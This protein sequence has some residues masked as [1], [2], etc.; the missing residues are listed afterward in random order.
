MDFRQ[1]IQRFKMDLLVKMPFYGVLFSKLNIRESDRDGVAWT[2]GREI[3]YN[4]KE[5]SQFTLDEFHYVL[6]HELLHIILLHPFRCE[7]RNPLLWNVAC[8]LSVNQLLDE[9]IAPAMKRENIPFS[10]PSGV[11]SMRYYTKVSTETIYEVLKQ[12]KK[13]H[14]LLGGSVYV[15]NCYGLST[16]GVGKTLSGKD[17]PND[18]TDAIKRMG[19]S[20]DEAPNKP[21][22]RRKANDEKN[23]MS[24]EE[25]K[26]VAENAIRK[27]VNEAARA[28][29]VGTGIPY[30]IP[31]EL[32]EFTRKPRLNWKVLLRDFLEEKQS[33]DD[34]S[35]TTPE[36]K[37][38]HMD[39]ILPGHCLTEE[40]PEEIWAFV[41][42]S[43][44]ISGEQ[45]RRFLNELYHLVKQFSCR[46]NIAYWDTTV[47][48]VYPKITDEKE[49][50]NSLP[51]STGGTDIN[52]V[53]AWLRENNTKPD[54]MLVLT[55]GYFG[56]A[57]DVE[58]V[59]KM[60]R[61]TVMVLSQNT[62]GSEFE[63]Y[64][65]VALLDT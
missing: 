21:R 25:M 4:P 60:R 9:E 44:S 13:S 5:C 17:V 63:K 45:M 15:R 34:A 56:N 38:L 58:L 1:E 2:D 27:L 11:L 59:R 47:N 14:H 52:C 57:T 6:M 19:A 18:I 48:S 20:D 55:D 49:I 22:W 30:S 65:K 23:T 50:E 42:S 64:G 43:G 12:D 53:Y 62:G 41:D 40:G 3:F 31:D 36:R 35:Y 10:R 37:Y 7:R 46:M 32:L 39:L 33:D 54:V 8:D 29:G 26:R 61:K 24:P 16:P 51:K 28:A